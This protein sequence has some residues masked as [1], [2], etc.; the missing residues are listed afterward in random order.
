MFSNSVNQIFQYN[1]SPITFQKGDSVMVNATE[2]A[3]PFGKLAKDW[4]SN[5]STKE[6]LSTL[7]SVR[8]IP[9]TALVEI[10]QGGNKEQ[11]TWMHEDVAMEFARWLSPAF[12]IW[13]NDRIKE[14][15]TIGMTATQPTL[16]QMI[17]NPDLVIH[18][19]TQLKQEREERAKL[20]AQTEQQQVT[21]KIQ[22]EEIKQAAPKVSYY[23]NHLQSVNTLTS[24]QVAKQIG[25][26]AE[27]LH[28][29]MKEI[30]ILYKQSGQWILHAPY[31]TWGLHSTRTQTYTRS[32]GST[33]T[34][35][36]TV[37]TTKGVRFII[38]LYENEWNVKKA[39]KQIKSEVNPAA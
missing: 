36:Y 17:D 5:K 37:W 1:G 25:M 8:T 31:S 28:R 2:M 11:G 34:S 32:D 15:L 22:T 30:G 20:E 18:L 10:K 13:C 19:A 6:F 29:K 38:A 39:I 27:K 3:K 16:E 35:V 21:I 12:A 26:D 23:D 9:L 24:T 7:S 4:L 14:L 33:G